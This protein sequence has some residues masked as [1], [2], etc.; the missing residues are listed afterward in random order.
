MD[1]VDLTRVFLQI[2]IKEVLQNADSQFTLALVEHDGARLFARVPFNRE[3]FGTCAGLFKRFEQ[4]LRFGFED[5]TMDGLEDLCRVVDILK[6]HEC[7]ARRMV[8]EVNTGIVLLKFFVAGLCG[9]EGM[10]A[11]ADS[12]NHGRTLEA[13]V[14]L[15]DRSGI[16]GQRFVEVFYILALNKPAG[17]MTAVFHEIEVV[18]LFERVLFRGN[19]LDQLLVVVVAEHQHMRQFNRSVAADTLTRR[20]AFGYGALGGADGAGRAGGIV[21]GIEID[22]TDKALTDGAVLQRALDIDKAVGVDC[23]HAVFH[24]FFHGG[25]DLGSV[26][27]FFLGAEFGFGEDQVDGGHSTLGI[28]AHTVP[29]RLI[30]RKLIAGNDRPFFHMVCFGHQDI[31]G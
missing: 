25:V 17:N 31:S 2:I 23:E 30:R 29:V 12:K 8:G 19:R 21:I 11:V 7:I 13:G 1:I 26:F 4:L 15:T 9:C 6:F 22:H 3:A 24:V 16:F 20:D 18:K 27:R 14:L 10:V 5:H 28:F